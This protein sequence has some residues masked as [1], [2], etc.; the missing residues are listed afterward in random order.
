MS[1]GDRS[2]VL[3]DRVIAE[4][5]HYHDCWNQENTD[6]PE[7]STVYAPVPKTCVIPE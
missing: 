2:P 1:D 6:P 7:L 4:S 5:T 3:P